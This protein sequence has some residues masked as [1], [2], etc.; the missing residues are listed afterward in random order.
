MNNKKLIVPLLAV[1]LLGGAA[2]GATGIASAA[3]SAITSTGTTASVQAQGDHGPRGMGRPAVM[4]TVS[5]ISGNSITVT[6]KQSGTS[7]TVDATNAKVMK[8][9]TGSAPTTSAVSDIAVGDT[10]M[11]QGTTSGTTVTAT[12]IMDG[13]FPDRGGPGGPGGMGGGV[14]GTVSAINGSTLT[15]STKDGGTYTVDASSATVKASGTTSSVSAIKVG[16]TVRV[17]G[18]VTTASMTAKN[19]D[20]GVP[21]PPAAPSTTSTTSN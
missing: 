17:G 4:G 5:A 9:A 20:D 19:I 7:Y 10:V 18:T 21:T 11:V 6:D 2:A 1:A 12:N 15:I 3:T 16:D 14:M 13:Q 8:A